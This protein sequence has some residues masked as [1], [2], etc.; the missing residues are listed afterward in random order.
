MKI[1]N[2]IDKEMLILH[3]EMIAQDIFDRRRSLD[4]VKTLIKILAR[5]L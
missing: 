2:T 5:D 1:S 3:R 4:G